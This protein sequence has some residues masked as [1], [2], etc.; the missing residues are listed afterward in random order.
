[1][2]FHLELSRWLIKKNITSCKT[3]FL[4]FLLNMLS[5]DLAIIKNKYNLNFTTNIILYKKINFLS[6]FFLNDEIFSQKSTTKESAPIKVKVKPNL[7]FRPTDQFGKLWPDPDTDFLLFDRVVN[8]DKG[9]TVPLG[10]RGTVV[11]IYEG[12]YIIV[13]YYL[14]NLRLYPKDVFE[15]SF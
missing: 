11:G 10:L 3:P 15:T 9:I 5:F 8:V 4:F 2:T 1:M 13:L 6:I 12:M 7:I 14:P